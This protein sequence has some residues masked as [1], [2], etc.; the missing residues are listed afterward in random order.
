LGITDPLAALVQ[1]FSFH[2]QLMGELA[3][4]ISGA[5]RTRCGLLHQ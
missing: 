3:A 1:A 4:K 5:T 2:D